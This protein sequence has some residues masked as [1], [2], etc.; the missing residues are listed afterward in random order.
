V[1]LLTA[2]IRCEGIGYWDEGS[3]ARVYRSES[4][5]EVLERMDKAGS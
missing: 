3:R 2:G 4:L 1:Q 5:Y